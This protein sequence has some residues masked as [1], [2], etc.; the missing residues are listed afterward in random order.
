MLEQHTKPAVCAMQGTA[1]QNTLQTQPYPLR[2][3]I[4]HPY[5]EETFLQRRCLAQ[6]PK[7]MPHS[8]CPK[9]T[10]LLQST[11]LQRMSMTVCLNMAC[12]QQMPESFS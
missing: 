12:L 7:A 11:E 10:C 4:A 3:T 2:S 8:H 6:G 9:V 5:R 1:Y